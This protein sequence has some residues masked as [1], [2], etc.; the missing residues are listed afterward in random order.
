ME[1]SSPGSNPIYDEFF[2]K[3][4]AIELFKHS[5]AINAFCLIAL[6]TIA[7]LWS[8]IALTS[9][10][11]ECRI[12]ATALMMSSTFGFSNVDPR[13]IEL[14]VEDFLSSTILPLFLF[15]YSF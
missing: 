2:S 5:F 7:N 9:S 12:V 1:W 14:I 3:F 11:Y 10:I 13:N 8:G 4:L 6:E 15:N